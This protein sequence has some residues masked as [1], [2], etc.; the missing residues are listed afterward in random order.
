[1]RVSSVNVNG[2]RAAM[3]KGMAEWLARRE[4]DFL[5]LQETR[6]DAA[7]VSDLLGPKW[8][9]A[10]E[11]SRLKGRAGVA[12]ASREEPVAVRA[13]LPGE[14]ADVDSGRWVEADFDTPA[15]R[16]TLVSTYFHSGT[17]GT[18]TMALKYA[19]LELVSAR[20]AELVRLA[21]AGERDVLV[22]GDFNIVGG[23]LDLRNYRANHNR[24]A[25]ALD[26]EMAYLHRWFGELGW[27][28]VHREVV[29][30]VQGPYTWWSQRGRA[31]D[32]DTGWRIDYQIAT[33]GLA[34][35]ARTALVDRAPAWDARFSDHAPLTVDYVL[36]GRTA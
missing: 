10:P 14:K 1:M 2:I 29:G 11:V 25:G 18:P 6:A 36:A 3:R 30:E 19:H 9:V 23:P 16:L 34:A 4:P 26:P 17:A 22:A 15:G 21:A 28:D 27:R 32:N 7:I 31:F 12:V 24:V 20:L 33:P 13:G 5:L 35:T 8:H